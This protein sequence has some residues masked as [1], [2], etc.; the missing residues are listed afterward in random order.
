MSNHFF[1]E[2]YLENNLTMEEKFNQVSIF[3]SF[4]NLVGEAEKT[5][6][7]HQYEN[8]IK[9]WQD[10]A[11]ITGA[12]SWQQSA[13]D[14]KKLVTDFL[15]EHISEPQQLFNSWLKLRRQMN[16][17]KLSS[18]AYNMMQQLYAK[19]FLS[20]KQTVSF[21]IATGVFCY[22]EERYETAKENLIDVLNREPD[23]LL[24]RIFLSKCYFT[25]ADENK[26]M[27]TL[28]QTIFLGCNEILPEDIGA[29]PIKNLYGRLRSIHGK[30]E[31]GVWLVPF[32]AWYRSWLIW[33]EDTPFFQVM[34]QKERN[35]RILQVKYYASEKYRHFVRCLY[36]AEYVREFLPKEKGI[37][38]EQEAYMEKLDANLFQRYRK[39][40]K[41]IV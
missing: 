15:S 39:K 37:I 24:A 7:E 32:E 30:G 5:F 9:K 19:L 10:Y 17:N 35:E 25:L 3:E 26:G 29:P 33:V 20:S 40:R 38:W 34:Q 6:F 18:Y 31:A 22:I 41:P 12:P 8:A 4:D 11:Q 27:A 14:I 28:S 21:D 13:N 16:E 36:I 2:E 1:G 23:N